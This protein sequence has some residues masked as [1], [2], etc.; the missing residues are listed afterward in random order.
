M[1]WKVDETMEEAT[2]QRSDFTLANQMLGAYAGDAVYFRTIMNS[3]CTNPLR[4][5]YAFKDFCRLETPLTMHAEPSKMNPRT[6]ESRSVKNC[7]RKHIL[8]IGSGGVGLCARPV[9]CLRM[10]SGSHPIEN[11]SLSVI[12]MKDYTVSQ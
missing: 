11:E 4:K 5:I 9:M 6:F 10:G 3:S 7:R 2:E 12:Q 1:R 8:F